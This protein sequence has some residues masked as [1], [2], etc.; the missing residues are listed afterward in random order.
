MQPF[1]PTGTRSHGRMGG[2]K[3]S[4]AAW[5]HVTVVVENMAGLRKQFYADPIQ[6]D[7]TPP[8]LCCVEHNGLEG[9]YQTNDVVSF[10][11]TAQDNDSGVKECSW[12]LGEN[13]CSSYSF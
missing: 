2:L 8:T 9:G 5:V 1:K 10:T 11:W 13:M 4:H 6:I 3:I 12:A 7:L